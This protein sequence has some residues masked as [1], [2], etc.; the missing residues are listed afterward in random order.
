MRYTRGESGKE[1][2]WSQTLRNWKKMDASEILREKTQC[3]RKCQRQWVADKSYVPNRRLEQSNF[4][5]EI[6]IS[7]NVHLNPGS[8]RPRRRTRQSSR[9]FRRIFFNPTSSFIVVWWWSLEMIFCPC[10]GSFTYRHHAEPRVKLCVPREESLPIP[11]QWHRRYQKL[12]LHPRMYC[13]RKDDWN[14]DG[15]RELSDA[16]TG[17]TRFTVLNEKP[18]DGYAWSVGRLIRKRTT[19]RPDTLWPEIWK[20][21]SDA[22]KRTEK[23][24]WA[25]EKPKLDNARRLRGIYFIDPDDEE[26][27]DIMYNARRKLEIP[28][29]AAMLLQTSTW[30]V[31]GNLLGSWRTLDKICLH[32]WS[33]RI[34][35]ET[36]GRIS[37]QV[38][39][40]SCCRK[41]DELI[42]S[43]QFGAANLLFLV[44]RA[45]EHTSCKGSSGEGM[46]K[47]PENSGMAADEKSATQNEVI[48]EARNKGKTVHFASLMDLCHLK[49][50]ELEPQFQKYKP[51]SRTPRWHCE[52]WF[53]I[54]CS[55]YW[56]R[57]ISITNDSR[58]SNGYKIK[59][60]RMRRTSNRRSICLSPGK[61][62]GLSK[63]APISSQN[64][65]TYGYVFHLKIPKSECPDMWIRLPKHMWPESWSSVE[66]PVVYL[67]RIFAV[68]L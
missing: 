29:P 63:V 30:E 6:R 65:Q 68:I 62:G 32:C 67:E 12:Q 2:S 26:F 56:A 8:S 11:L 48:A 54:V 5:E 1:T 61:N 38:S 60:T 25:I 13:W 58:K 43:Q 20:D 10:S 57:I 46:G 23:L 21:V 34:H 39:W 14:V 47:T 16:W 31:Q 59:T 37:S 64:V 36:H 7:Q 42:E 27:K 19:S 66:D 44:P 33:R 15:D 41:R 9:R 22:S 50:S 53:R 3:R 49:N 28:M 4:L 24:K 18:P 17:V 35:E 55:I 45:S 52:R 51:S 40:R